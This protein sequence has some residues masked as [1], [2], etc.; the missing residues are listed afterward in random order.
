MHEKSLRQTALAL[1]VLLGGVAA[2]AEPRVFD[3]PDAVEAVDVPGRTVVGGVPVAMHAV[4][5]RRDA[6][7]LQEH[8]RAE[9]RKAK[10]WMGPQTQLTVHRQ[11]TGLDVDSLI[12][13]SVFL[14]ENRDRTT[15]V[16]ISET[17]VGEQRAESGLSFA[18]QVPGARSVMVART[19]GV[20]LASY[21]TSMTADEVR[22]FYGETLGKAG[23]T[24]EGAGRFRRAGELLEVRVTAR[25]AERVVSL[26]RRGER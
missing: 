9:F 1:S 21:R 12:A 20:E 3:V 8:F 26:S 13:Y 22:A 5:S 19:E 6:A 24:P 14:Q 17:F 15:T 2:A 16:I 10:L 7:S 23:W 4:R 18:P 11:V 25:E